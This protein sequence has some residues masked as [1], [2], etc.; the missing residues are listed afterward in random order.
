M[1]KWHWG[2]A[3]HASIRC[4]EADSAHISRHGL[5]CSFLP[6]SDLQP[7]VRVPHDGVDYQLF[8]AVV[9][10][11]CAHSHRR[12]S[13]LPNG[14]DRFLSYKRNFYLK[15]KYQHHQWTAVSNLDCFW[16]G[17]QALLKDLKIRQLSSFEAFFCWNTRHPF[18]GRMNPTRKPCKRNPRA[19][20]QHNDRYDT[21]FAIFNFIEIQLIINSASVLDL[22]C[23]SN[24]SF[25]LSNDN[26]SH[27]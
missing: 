5:N 7:C 22:V 2:R 13:Y 25:F 20:R 8:E 4:H 17:N 18:S 9:S 23:T 11:T 15:I 3:V 10:D 14:G 21:W 16:C 24:H 6:L 12:W 26:I 19:L 27:D 1:P